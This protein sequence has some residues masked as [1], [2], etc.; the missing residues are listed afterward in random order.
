[1]RWQQAGGSYNYDST[2]ATAIGGYPK[3]AILLNSA[4]TGFWLNGADNNT[5]DPDS[6]GTNWTAVIS[7]AASTTAAGIIAI[8]TT[9]QAQAMTSDVVALTPKK[10]A[11][12]FAGSR[13]GVT[14]NG[15]QILPNGLI[16]QWASGAQQ[17]VPQN[18]S[19][20][21]ISI[22]LPIPF[23]NAALFALG[24]CRYVSGTHGYT[25]TV[26]LST[27]AAVVDAS[28]GS[29]SGGNA[30]LVPGVLVVGY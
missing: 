16:L 18:S 30:V 5:T 20:T 28:N 2:F 26:S 13:Q 3:G 17:T 19:N 10:L 24:T 21:N 12:A 25:T 14:A 29:V 4:G 6:G 23:P 15:Y 7:N 9:A 1:M 8:A 22:T 11:D 27:S